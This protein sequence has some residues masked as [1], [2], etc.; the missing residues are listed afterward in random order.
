M[1]QE[2]LAGKDYYVGSFN[3][4]YLVVFMQNVIKYL[5]SKVADEG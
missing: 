1:L 2:G 3:I 5:R 4:L